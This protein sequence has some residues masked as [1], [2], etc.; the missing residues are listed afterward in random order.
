MGVLDVKHKILDLKEE[1]LSS[2]EKLIVKYEECKTMRNSL[3]EMS[4]KEIDLGFE[5][6]LL[7]EEINEKDIYLKGI[8]DCLDILKEDNDNELQSGKS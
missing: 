3:E 8:N 7:S 5:M 4:K 6:A 1:A 2:I